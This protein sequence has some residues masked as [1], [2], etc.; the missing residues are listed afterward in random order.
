[1]NIYYRILV[2][3]FVC[4]LAACGVSESESNQLGIIGIDERVEYIETDLNNHVGQILLSGVPIC[5]AF[6]SRQFEI[7]TAAH[8]VVEEFLS[9]YSFSSIGGV[10]SKFLDVAYKNEN[11]DFLSLETA[12][13]F[14]DW[15]EVAEYDEF[16]PTNI[17]GFN[18]DSNNFF[19]ST[20]SAG[21][22]LVDNGL[23]FHT[24]D[25]KTG[26]SG[27]P[28]LQDGKVI[29]M[30]IGSNTVDNVSILL[31]Y[32]YFIEEDILLTV[33]VP[34]VGHLVCDLAGKYCSSTYKKFGGAVAC[35]TAESACHK[36]MK[37][38]R[39]KDKKRAKEKK[40]AEAKKRK[41]K[42]AAALKRIRARQKAEAQA[43]ARAER[44][45][46][47]E[48]DQSLDPGHINHCK[49]GCD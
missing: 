38:A 42:A 3:T 31:N 1:M 20:S 25:T 11:A 33:E 16:L 9:D 4:S 19:T 24:M 5:S 2:L 13:E 28:I 40:A 21:S 36:A 49:H 35:K 32:E 34:E 12:N 14:K 6:V 30:H 37:W 48:L 47:R 15:L 17:V 8:C 44:R 27:A 39:K 29:A 23:M 7:T 45:R 18:S 41:E 43:E 22:N 10:T 46:E 26:A